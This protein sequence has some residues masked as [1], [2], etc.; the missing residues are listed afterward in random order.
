VILLDGWSKTYAMTGWRLG[1]GIWPKRLVDYVRKLITIDH[2]CVNVAAQMA[3][4]AAV[5]GPQDAVLAM[6]QSFAERRDVVVRGLNRLPNVSC[7]TPGGAFYAFPNV[8]ATGWTS[9]ELAQRLLDEAYVALV[10]GESFGANGQGFLRLS[11][12]ASLAD[13]EEA[14]ARMALFLVT[15]RPKA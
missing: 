14:L 3:G 8:S 1:Y 13:I 6:R 10:P 2:S 11:Y 12:A 4:L 15:A 9:R 5:T 7:R